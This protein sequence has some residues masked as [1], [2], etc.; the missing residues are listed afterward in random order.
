M[1]TGEIVGTSRPIFFF[2]LTN[3]EIKNQTILILLLATEQSYI[4]NSVP[5]AFIFT[6]T[7][8]ESMDSIRQKKNNRV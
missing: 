8:L 6:I 5:A 4:H 2:S 7:G 3:A 1:T